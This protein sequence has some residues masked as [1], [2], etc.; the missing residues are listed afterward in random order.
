MHSYWRMIMI[1]WCKSILIDPVCAIFQLVIFTVVIFCL[2]I[3]GVI[4][5]INTPFFNGFLFVLIDVPDWFV[6]VFLA[7]L[8]FVS[9]L[10]S[11]WIVRNINKPHPAV[12]TE[13]NNKD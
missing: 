9:F 4:A 1:S 2:S 11:F 8:F 7:V 12:P 3:A 13:E 5:L 10:I 6:I